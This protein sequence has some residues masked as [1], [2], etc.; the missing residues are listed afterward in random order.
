MR[1]LHRCAGFVLLLAPLAP[2]MRADVTLRYHT[3]IK[4]TGAIGVSIPLNQTLGGMRDMVIR[5]KGNKAY[6]S[7]GNLFSIMD[8]MTQ[9]L[10][11]V[12]APHKRFAT[13]PASQYAEQ[14]KSVIPAIPEQARAVF[15]SMKSN[16]VFR[17]TGRTAVIQG[18]QAE[19]QEF[20][21]TID[22]PLP[23]APPMPGPF[24]KMVMQVWTAKPEEARRVPTL[25][26][27]KNYTA[28]A[29]S[30]MNP[31]E[32]MKQVLGGL[33]GMGDSIGAMLEEVSKQ[34]SMSL[35]MHA[36]LFMPV[37]ALMSRQL[38]QQPGQP[39]LPALDPDAPL[40]QM[41]QEVVELS[42]DPLDDALFQVPQDYQAAPL[43]EILKAAVSPAAPALP[44]P[45]AAARP[46][47]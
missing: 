13:V 41:N 43:E 8:L 37:L 27:F 1:Q 2:S 28:S 35:R 33:P 17:S 23:G 29:S 26:E 12:D 39:P 25:Q 6:S 47:Q 46:Q 31:A 22:L 24:M 32:M 9:Q 40:L 5:I 4:T 7:Q 10:I 15:A 3:D 19:E 20:V 44:P 42:T 34:G 14:V 18:I 11:L 38:P 36:E 30:A 16:L 21:L 45:P